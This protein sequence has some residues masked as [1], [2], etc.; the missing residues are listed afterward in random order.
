VPSLL[1]GFSAPVVLDFPYAPAELT[2]LLAYDSDPFNAW[3]AGQRLAS[4][5]I[6]DAT[7][8][9]AAGRPAAWPAGFADAIR[10]LLVRHGERDAGLGG[11]ASSDPGGHVMQRIVV[12]TGNAGMHQNVPL[13]P[14]VIE[15]AKLIE[16]K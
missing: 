14:V 8:A 6:L 12:A 7:G 11:P 1:R 4:N 15:S 9:L 5:L 13:S 10:R 16:K 3:E 2:L